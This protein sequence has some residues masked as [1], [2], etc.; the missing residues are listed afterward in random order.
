MT[1]DSGEIHLH[2]GVRAMR[3]YD[4]SNSNG[5]VARALGTA[6]GMGETVY[7]SFLFRTGSTSPLADPDFFQLGFDS[8]LATGN[9]RVE[10]RKRTVVL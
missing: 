4:A 6:L 10:R 3:V 8:S 9:P 7:V 5:L 1:Y 2:G